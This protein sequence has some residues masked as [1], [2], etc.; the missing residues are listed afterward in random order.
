M[1]PNAGSVTRKHSAP[2]HTLTGS[3][4]RQRAPSSGWRPDELA[5]DPGSARHVG[6]QRPQLH[7]S[8]HEIAATAVWQPCSSTPVKAAG[9]DKSLTSRPRRKAGPLV[10]NRP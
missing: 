5:K 9:G 8:A 2:K 7:T 4:A 1:S 10:G 3:G 6:N